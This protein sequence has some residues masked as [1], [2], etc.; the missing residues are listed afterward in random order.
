MSRENIQIREGLLMMTK[1]WKQIE[2]I[3]SSLSDATKE[4]HLSFEKTDEFSYITKSIE[5]DAKTKIIEL[6]K[7]IREAQQKR[8]DMPYKNKISHSISLL[9]PLSQTKNP[10][11]AKRVKEIIHILESLL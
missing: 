11:A 8:R 9:R 2:L 1:T 10:K 4:H 3:E 6:D 7:I 5:F